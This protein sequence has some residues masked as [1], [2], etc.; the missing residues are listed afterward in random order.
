MIWDCRILH[1][2]KLSLFTSSCFLGDGAGQG[3][4]LLC[5]DT[6][7]VKFECQNKPENIQLVSLYSKVLWS[8]LQ[9]YR[10]CMHKHFHEWL[11]YVHFP[12]ELVS[13]PFIKSWNFR[14]I[15]SIQFSQL[16]LVLLELRRID[17]FNMVLW[18][19][20]LEYIV[21][22]LA[23]VDR[24]FLSDTHKS[25]TALILVILLLV[26]QELREWLHSNC[27][28]V[29]SKISVDIYAFSLVCDLLGVL[30]CICLSHLWKMHWT[31]TVGVPC[32]T[33]VPLTLIHTWGFQS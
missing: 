12:I 31:S 24:W 17:T 26:L 23:L 10:V 19:F 4:S 2:G 1:L 33:Q 11:F 27:C 15:L 13:Y 3:E 32:T 22:P 5:F 7:P 20:C 6:K 21:F 25:R 29:S 16:R 14:K 30:G 28:W 18:S 9:T 8:L